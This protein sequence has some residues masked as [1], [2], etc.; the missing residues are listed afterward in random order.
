MAFVPTRSPSTLTPFMSTLVDFPPKTGTQNSFTAG[1]LVGLQSVRQV[2]L[3]L[4][5]YANPAVFL[6]SLFGLDQ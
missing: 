5:N 3:P 6:Q 4:E 2:P 1:V